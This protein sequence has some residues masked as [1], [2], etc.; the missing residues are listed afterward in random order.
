M[1]RH[2]KRQFALLEECI[3]GVEIILQDTTTIKQS[4]NV[5]PLFLAF[6]YF[7]TPK[8]I[9]IILNNGNSAKDSLNRLY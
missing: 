2:A 5:S 9:K 7:F 4:D 8:I 1:T 3:F 6:S